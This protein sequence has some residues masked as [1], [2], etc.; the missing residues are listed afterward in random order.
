M[1]DG[2]TALH[3]KLKLGAC[4]CHWSIGRFEYMMADILQIEN[5]EHSCYNIDMQIGEFVKRSM[6][7]QTML[8][9][10]SPHATF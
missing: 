6:H 9:L 5:K 1:Y 8:I 3:V 4:Y 7:T 2:N 10:I